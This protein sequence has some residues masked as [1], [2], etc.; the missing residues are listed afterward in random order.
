VTS[1]THL[2]LDDVVVA[3]EVVGDGRLSDDRNDDTRVDDV[4]RLSS[5]KMRHA[6]SNLRRHHAPTSE[7]KV[8]N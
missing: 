6:S 3:G 5:T 7:T 1:R 8:D 4:Q 2:L